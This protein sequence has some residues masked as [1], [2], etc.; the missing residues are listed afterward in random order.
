MTTWKMIPLNSTAGFD[1]PYGIELNDGF[2]KG[3]TS[4]T[5]AHQNFLV[6]R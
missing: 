4:L 3:N 5:L 1:M 2:P 6:G